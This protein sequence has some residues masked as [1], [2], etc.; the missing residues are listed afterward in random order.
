MWWYDEKSCGGL[1]RAYPE[2]E[3]DT[4]RVS[5]Y[6]DKKSRHYFKVAATCPEDALR[7]Q[8]YFEKTLVSYY[9]LREQDVFESDKPGRTKRLDSRVMSELLPVA[10]QLAK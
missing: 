5:G 8:F 10:K 3:I 7:N 1:N 2:V 9:E 6:Y 4:W